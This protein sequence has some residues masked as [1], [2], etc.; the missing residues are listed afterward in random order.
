MLV[1]AVREHSLERDRLCGLAAGDQKPVEKA[2]KPDMKW[3]I[4]RHRKVIVRNSPLSAGLTG[5]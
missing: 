2:I 3:R 5:P 4:I 1:P